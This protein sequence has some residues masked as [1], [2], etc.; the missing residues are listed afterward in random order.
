MKTLKELV[1]GAKYHHEKYAGTGYYEGLKGEEIPREARIIAAADTYDAMTT[2]R[3]YRKGLSHEVAINELVRYSGTQ[4]DPEV[5]KYFCEVID[6][7]I[8]DHSQL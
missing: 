5:V 8:E 6:K 4:F 7:K 1:G 3:P 2:D